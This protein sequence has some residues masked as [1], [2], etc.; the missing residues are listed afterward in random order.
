MRHYHLS[1]PARHMQASVTF[2][3]NLGLKQID[4]NRPD[5]ARF[6]SP[7]GEVTLL[8]ERT[9]AVPE[10][11]NTILF[12]ECDDLDERVAELRTK[13]LLFESAPEDQPW[14]WRDAYLKDPKG[15]SVCL[16]NSGKERTSPSDG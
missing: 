4:E 13:G 16:F 9:D 7:E 1:I 6:L 2:Y 15:N 5:E 12:F 11:P 14:G 10:K 3:K 8:L